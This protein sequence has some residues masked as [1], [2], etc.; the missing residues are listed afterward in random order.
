MSRQRWESL[1]P[2]RAPGLCLPGR[3]DTP[4]PEPRLQT[5][6]MRRGLLDSETATLIVRMNDRALAEGRIPPAT[7]RVRV[8]YHWVAPFL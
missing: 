3:G 6:R 2:H 4:R 8:V 5:L 7:Q 1:G